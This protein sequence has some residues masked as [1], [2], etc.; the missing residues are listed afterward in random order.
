MK[1]RIVLC[2]V[3]ALLMAGHANAEDDNAKPEDLQSLRGDYAFVSSHSC[4]NSPSG[5]GPPPLLTALGPTTATQTTS[6]GV[7]TFRRDGTG[8]IVGRNAISNSTPNAA[9]PVTQTAFQC[10]LTYHL[11]EDGYYASEST[12]AGQVTLGIGS[13]V[14]ATFTSSP[15][16][17]SGYLTGKSLVTANT[18]LAVESSTSN[19][20]TTPRIC[21]RT[22]VANK[23][24]K[25]KD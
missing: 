15:S 23:I 9:N 10:S 14:G 4:I 24:Y 12:C 2:M 11:T 20:I 1:K 8:T 25:W 21:H 5:F 7:I 18:D 6:Q 19:G 22:T 13:R 3:G 17:S 16:P